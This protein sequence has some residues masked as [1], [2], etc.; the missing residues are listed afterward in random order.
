MRFDTRLFGPLEVEEEKVFV[1]PDGLYGFERLRRFVLIEAAAGSP[2][3]WLQSMEDGDISFVIVDP[4]AVEPAYAPSLAED[5]LA[6][7]D[8]RQ[9]NDAALFVIAVVPEDLRQMTVNLRAPL[10]F[11][12][13]ARLGCQ[14]ILS[15]DR[16]SVKYPVFAAL[17]RATDDAGKPG[18]RGTP[19]A[20]ATQ[21]V[22]TIMVGG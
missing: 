17:A 11:N 6:C 13:T 10:V 9:A 22:A 18:R 8:L 16:Y 4:F 14:V 15:D 12:P 5:H 21:S 7:I 19:A 2:W 20:G 1:L 3:K